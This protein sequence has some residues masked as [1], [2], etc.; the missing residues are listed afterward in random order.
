MSSSFSAFVANT[1]ENDLFAENGEVFFDGSGDIQ[2]VERAVVEVEDLIAP[3][4]S[5][6][7]VVICVGVETLRVAASFDNTDQP[8]VREG[9]NSPID[10]IK[11]DVRKR[12]FDFL[13]DYFCIRMFF[14]I[15]KHIVYG[16]TLR[17]D[18]ETVF[19]ALRNKK[20]GRFVFVFSFHT[21]T[22]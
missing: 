10:R 1:F 14:G 17:S 5:E 12:L 20:I 7:V 3:D 6:M 11:R 22:I 13:I 15:S 4:T 21:K 16:N 19:F 2:V 18:S 9:K 8:Y